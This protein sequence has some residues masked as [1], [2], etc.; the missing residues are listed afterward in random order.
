[1]GKIYK[2]QFNLKLTLETGVT[3]TGASATKIKYIKPDKITE[4]EFNASISGTEDLEYDFTV[5]TELDQSG[6]WTFWAYVT[7]SDS[8]IAPGEPVVIRVYEE[9]N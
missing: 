5:S 3:L 1:M 6:D 8:R 2:G 9:G 4:G 7:F